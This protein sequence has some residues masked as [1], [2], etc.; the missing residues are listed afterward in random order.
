MANDSASILA[1]TQMLLQE[2]VAANG[3][4]S[5][6]I[7]AAFFTVTADLTAAFP[8]RAARELGWTEV[9]LLD[10]LEIPVPGSLARCIRVL[11]LWN[12]ERPQ[13][14]IVHVYQGEAVCLRPDLAQK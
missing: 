12:T 8:A 7:A 4:E 9:P 1:A 10:A 13:S 3:I 14:E 6:E 11:L 2:L 5:E